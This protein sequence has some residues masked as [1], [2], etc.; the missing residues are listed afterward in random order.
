VLILAITFIWGYGWVLMKISL[1]YMGPFMFSALRFIVGSLTMLTILKWRKVPMPKREDWRYLGLLGLFQTS[2]VF[3]LIMYGLLFIGAGKSSVIL[4]SFPI[5]SMILAHYYLKEQVTGRKVWGL[6][7]GAIGLL[8][9]MGYQTL[10]VQNANVILGEGLII[11]ASFCWAIANM[12]M[13]KRFQYHDK[14]QVNTWQ[15]IF[16][17]VGIVIA[18]LIMEWGEPITLN[19][20]SI[21]AIVFCGVLASAFCFTGWFFI[22]TK[23]D[24]TV[25]S[26]SML[27]VPLF[28]LLFGWLQLGES[29][30]IEVMIGALLILTGVYF[31]TVQKLNKGFERR[32]AFKS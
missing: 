8:C 2:F 15:M 21:F 22:L 25:A 1:E 12:I 24:T 13:K 29:L 10:R 11:L 20:T 9:I 5:W 31:T 7:L 19:V 28:A 23:I 16:G 4:Y 6:I 3:L 30:S 27:F 32:K 18:A 26:V 14:F 17:T